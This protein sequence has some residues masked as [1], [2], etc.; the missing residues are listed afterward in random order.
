[1]AGKAGVAMFAAVAAVGPVAALI[2]PDVV[3]WMV[4]AGYEAALFFASVAAELRKRWL[5]RA[6]DHVDE[7]LGRRFTRFAKRYREYMLGSLRSIDLKGLTTIGFYN[8]DLDEVFVDVG[9]DLSAPHRVPAGVVSEQPPSPG[10]RYSLW[11]FL[12]N[13]QPA[14][15]AILGAPGSGKTTLLRYTARR[16]LDSGKRRTIPIL[17]YL[18][19]HITTITPDVTLPQLATRPLGP[20]GKSEPKGWFEQRLRDGDCVVLL[21][22]LDE[23]A[24]QEDRGRIAE[25][26]ETQIARYPRNDFVIT[27]RPHG[28]KSTSISGSLI[29]HALGFTDEQVRKFVQGWYL[30]V[31]RHTK[32]GTPAEA[33]QRAHTEAN[34]LLSRLNNSPNLTDLTVNPLLLTM[35]TNVHRFRGALPGSRADLYSEICQVLLWRR[36]EAKKLTSEL[37]GDKKEALLRGLAFTMMERRVRD[38]PTKDVLDA[39][40][41]PLDRIS[42]QVKPADFLADASSNG[43]LVERDVGMY[44]FAHL[45][46]QEYLAASH[47]REKGLVKTLADNVEDDWWRETTLLYTARSDAD[48]IVR[49]CLRSNTITALS[50]AFD[51][52]EQDSELDPT[53]A[54]ELETRF[55]EGL[56]PDAA[57]D[58]R[59]LA[60]GVL[61]NRHLRN[62]IQVSTGR[63]CPKPITTQLYALY[64]RDT[65]A[66]PVRPTDDVFLG[67][68]RSEAA[69]FASWVWSVLDNTQTYRLPTEQEIMEPVV[70]RALGGLPLSVW[71][72]TRNRTLWTNADP[73]PC[74]VSEEIVANHVRADLQRSVDTL[75]RCVALYAVVIGRQLIEF[76][77]DE[78]AVPLANMLNDTSSYNGRQTIIEG[79]AD[80]DLMRAV[81]IAWRIH[82]LARA[83]SDVERIR[84]LAYGLH[85]R[86]NATTDLDRLLF[87]DRSRLYNAAVVYA[88]QSIPAGQ[89]VVAER[90]GSALFRGLGWAIKGRQGLLH[91]GSAASFLDDLDGRSDFTREFLMYTGPCTDHVVMLDGLLS[92][93]RRSAASLRESGGGTLNWG[94][95]VAANLTTELADPIDRQSPLTPE[96]ATALRLTA[97]CLAAEADIH[98]MRDI[99]DNYRYIAAGVT[100][101]ERR[102]NGKAPITEAIILATG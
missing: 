54:Q 61:L 93:A 50:L 64:C 17:L 100:L 4:V 35:I 2:W 24:R 65:G 95:E 71:L 77:P 12:D 75:T 28:Y 6:V 97:L 41:I 85:S 26:V 37:S 66:L 42:R 47:I 76:D 81:E 29:L 20:L 68:L 79:S 39:I 101:M 73:H 11:D 18:R 51:C 21:D 14:V 3:K 32:N 15:L 44:S 16:V 7:A 69:N 45:T 59:R 67:V 19:D 40:K 72:N 82:R 49:A 8:P 83:S 25:W 88:R 94:A 34:D 48:E 43:L 60:A 38:L 87:T 78:L 5:N 80:D 13:K 1:M 84:R 91:G 63:V 99:G 23:V 46:F 96:K 98:H 30:A 33:A 56:H 70:Q 74:L 27:S 55:N 92:M 53:L 22:G 57:P 86:T 36:Q 52:T 58:R 31:E 89:E 10:N 62:T 102:A 90:I 9:L